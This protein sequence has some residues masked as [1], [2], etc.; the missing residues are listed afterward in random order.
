MIAHIELGRMFEW[1]LKLGAKWLQKTAENT[2]VGAIK[3]RPEDD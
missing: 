3:P 1:G 2:M